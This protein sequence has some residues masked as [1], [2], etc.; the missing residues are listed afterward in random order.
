MYWLI[1]LLR[2][3]TFL[4][5]YT[6]WLVCVWCTYT[7]MCLS[8]NPMPSALWTEVKRIASQKI[9]VY[10]YYPSLLLVS[11][12][13]H[14][15]TVQVSVEPTYGPLELQWILSVPFCSSICSLVLAPP[16][17]CWTRT[18]NQVG[19]LVCLPGASEIDREAREGLCVQSLLLNWKPGCVFEACGCLR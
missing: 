10:D 3:F 13:I 8:S 12:Y 7:C 17:H 18:M 19:R 15:K 9:I 1:W 2:T 16:A 6:L 5:L 4:N 11:L 14:K